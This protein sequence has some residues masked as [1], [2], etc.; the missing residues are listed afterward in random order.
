VFIDPGLP[1]FHLVEVHEGLWHEP[2]MAEGDYVRFQVHATHP[3]WIALR[4]QM[5]EI[6]GKL[7]SEGYHAT[8]KHKA[9]YHHEIRMGD[10][11]DDS[12][13]ME[14]YVRKYVDK[15]GGDLPRELLLAEGLGILAKARDAS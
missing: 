8:Y 14:D 10:E 13:T 9:I 4:P 7:R 5:N 15:T 1:K 2:E 3:E 6:T 11:M 12:V